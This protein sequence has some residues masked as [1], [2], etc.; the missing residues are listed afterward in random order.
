MK[1]CIKN[2]KKNCILSRCLDALWRNKHVIISGFAAAILFVIIY[3]FNVLDTSNIMW[4]ASGDTG[5]HYFAAKAYRFA[6]WKFPFGLFDSLSYPYDY[7]IVYYDAI[8]LL[9]VIQKLLSPILPHTFQYFGFW[10]LCCMVLQGA[11]SARVLRKYVKT[12]TSAIIGSLLFAVSP[13]MI[14]RVFYHSSLSAHWIIMLSLMFIAYYDE[15]YCRLIASVPAWGVVGFITVGITPY[16]TPMCGII[17]LG[18]I[19]LDLIKTKRFWR[20]LA[21]LGSFVTG[22]ALN[23]YFLGAFS[24]PAQN[25]SLGVTQFS[26]NLA[27]FFDSEGIWSRIFPDIPGAFADQYEGFAYL[28]AGVFALLMFSVIVLIVAAIK[29]NISQKI[30]KHVFAYAF[31]A[32]LSTI[33]ALSPAVTFAGRVLFTVPLP[34]A[35]ID[36]WNI[37]RATGR[38]IWPAVYILMVFAVCSTASHISKK[39]LAAVLAAAVALQGYDIS[40]Q[41]AA[42][43]AV[44]SGYSAYNG[45][46]SDEV[47]SAIAKDGGYKHIWLSNI[48]KTHYD[49]WFALSDYASDHGMTMNY[50]HYA[51]SLGSLNGLATLDA[52]DN[53]SEDGIYIIYEEDKL[54]CSSYI[55]KLHF[56][57]SECY[58]IGVSRPL[59]GVR[60]VDLS[61][62]TSYDFPIGND[63]WLSNGKDID[64]V[65]KI[66]SGG[67]S[68]GPYIAAGE[69]SYTVSIKGNGLSGA[70]FD[71]YTTVNGENISWISAQPVITDTSAELTFTVPENKFDIQI[72]IQNNSAG[73]IEISEY[74]VYKK[75]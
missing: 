5:Q 47:W 3:G 24:C 4:L 56:Y 33:V 14:T 19:L 12:D 15:K 11:I 48:I 10:G 72:Y 68:F 31:A 39:V 21:P 35:I 20:I 67:F 26:F 18:F 34:Q 71:C 74:T 8:P 65:R 37:F 25:S 60:E 73:D 29:K 75:T 6:E 58:Y 61:D 30:P 45:S 2:K 13:I 27:G 46:Y 57:K 69:G 16:L 43:H 28:G 36:I 63:G 40:G 32:F 42:K 64:G 22:A 9:A 53:P 55:D 50:F 52:Y 66:Y 70:V 41:L 23:A 59:D 44:F 49:R 51:R 1:A 38:L 54:I 62:I 17:L 7:S